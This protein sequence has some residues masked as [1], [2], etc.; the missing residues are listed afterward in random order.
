MIFSKY[1]ILNKFHY[2]P[3]SSEVWFNVFQVFLEGM[4]F[5]LS[6]IGRLG[7]WYPV[8]GL[9][10]QSLIAIM[11]KTNNSTDFNYFKLCSRN[12]K[13][14]DSKRVPRFHI[15]H[16]FRLFKRSSFCFV[17]SYRSFRLSNCKRFLIKFLK[18]RVHQK[19]FYS[20]IPLKIVIGKRII[21]CE[22]T[23]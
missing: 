1:Y 6:L 9:I 4:G 22:Q 20:E 14:S 10:C 21:L 8:K 5:V 11:H 15:A 17:F 3:F 16:I 18:I 2:N 13:T 19:E 23:L 7:T 12:E